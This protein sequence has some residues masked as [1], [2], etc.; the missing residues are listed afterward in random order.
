MELGR[1][2]T[3]VAKDKSANLAR[4]FYQDYYSSSLTM[5]QLCTL[6]AMLECL[7]CLYDTYRLIKKES[8]CHGAIKPTSSVHC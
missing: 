4:K 1:V 7:T 6:E 2:Q 3:A 8:I 5:A